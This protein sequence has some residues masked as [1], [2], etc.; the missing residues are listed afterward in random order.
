MQLVPE[1]TLWQKAADK[2][3]MLNCSVLKKINNNLKNTLWWW[4]ER[5]YYSES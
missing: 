3:N 1:I 2:K 5:N 4:G